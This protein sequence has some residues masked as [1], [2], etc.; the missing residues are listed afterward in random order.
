MLTAAKDPLFL[1]L[2]YNFATSMCV[3]EIG[4]QVLKV[5]APSSK[6]GGLLATQIAG[7]NEH[8]KLNGLKTWIEFIEFI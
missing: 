2:F 3:V 4:N 7:L 5:S 8:N 1:T 6:V